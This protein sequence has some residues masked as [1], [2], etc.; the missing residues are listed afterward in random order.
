MPRI[1]PRLLMDEETEADIAEL[2]S[3]RKQA[4]RK[5]APD[6]AAPRETELQLLAAEQ[7]RQGNFEFS[8][9][10]SRHERQWI[11]DSLGGFYEDHWIDDILRLVKGGKEASVYQCAA[12]PATSQETYLA[13]KVYRP[14][15]F[16]Q[17]RKDHL[18]RES[19]ADMDDEGRV[20]INH[21]MQHAIRSRSAY[22][23]ELLHKSWIEYEYQ[24]LLALHA[25]GAAVPRPY[26][27]ADN[28]ILMTYLG[29]AQEP[30]PTLNTVSLG[31]D[32]ARVLF[33]RLLHNVRLML[34]HGRVHG[35]LSA[36]NIL[37]WQGDIWL[38]DFP[39]VIDPT[40]HRQAYA[41]FER[42]LT[43]ACEYFQRQGVRCSP[44]RLAQTLWQEQGLSF[45]PDVHP[46]LLDDESE[47]DRRYWDKLQAK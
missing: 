5:A 3:R 28:A 18:Y 35:D 32:E 1:N 2:R 37:Y 42:D 10:A 26:A 15:M 6:K 7:E 40:H 19:R 20:I 13:A 12:H 4:R 16:R 43:R 47:A 24:S 8:Y 46:A 31:R 23:L 17:L 34:S 22:G 41:I 11:L 45:K 38:I 39:Q 14:R 44:R 36:Y 9:H 21:G 29:D 30:A 25:A 27:R 33:E